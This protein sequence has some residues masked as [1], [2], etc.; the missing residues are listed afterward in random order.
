MSGTRCS[1]YKYH[2][3]CQKSFYKSMSVFTAKRV[4]QNSDLKLKPKL[5]QN[6][7]VSEM[8][9]ISLRN[10]PA[11]LLSKLSPLQY[12][13]RTEESHSRGLEKDQAGNSKES[14]PEYEK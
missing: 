9:R 5:K 3:L 10:D 11:F 12:G 8:F 2:L 13:R 6:V 1:T 4:T 7:F 14:H